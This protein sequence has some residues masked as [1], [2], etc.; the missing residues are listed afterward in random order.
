MLKILFIIFIAINLN[1]FEILKLSKD[2]INTHTVGFTYFLEET[3]DLN[4]PNK[5]L[6]N[7]K[8]KLSKN[9]YIG[10]KSGPYWTQF[11]IKNELNHNK[12]FIISSS[13][14][15]ADYVDVYIYNKDKNLEKKYS[16]GDMREQAN[17][18]ILYRNPT[19]LVNIPANETKTIVTKFYNPGMYKIN[20]NIKDTISFID[21][22]NTHPLYLDIFIAVI[23]M[24]IIATGL[25]YKFYHSKVY[26][27]ILLEAILIPLYT[28]SVYG[29]LYELDI[30]IPL[31]VISFFAWVILFFI[32]IARLIFP[33]L[34]FDLK[35]KYPKSFVLLILTS[36]IFIFQAL[37]IIY[38][39]YFDASIIEPFGL[40]ILF[41]FF[42]YTFVLLL[43]AV[44]MYVKKEPYAI[45]YLLMQ[46][47]IVVMSTIHTL[48][49]IGILSISWYTP[50]LLHVMLLVDSAFIL[51][52]QYFSSKNKY[53]KSLEQNE[54]LLDQSRFYT[55][56]QTIGHVSHQWKTPLSRLGS[57]ISVID[58]LVQTD[59]SKVGDFVEEKIDS[60]NSHIEEMKFVVDNFSNIYSTSLQKKEFLLK[61]M[62]ENNIIILFE[63]KIVIKNVEFK[64]NIDDDLKVN[65]H[66]HVLSNIFMILIDNS[67]DAFDSNSE[68]KNIIEINCKKQNDNSYEINYSDNAGGIK[69]EPIEKVFE[70]FVSTKT[71]KESSGIGLP[72]L[73]LLV[74]DK[75]N[76]TVKVSN[77]N[78]GVIF[79]IRF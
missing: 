76:G 63:S 52:L 59:K 74:T 18:E 75:L 73:K 62:I 25:L 43:V 12:D 23:I 72:L 48:S 2:K 17:Q 36:S 38:T 51:I 46:V 32:P 8:L 4:T 65:S 24:I 30:G 64:L 16:L 39:R 6:N 54:M 77:S 45:Y 69:I 15:G 35:N 67:M 57:T 33:I 60:I 49:V 27:V 42:I 14:A 61:E 66:K 7:P 78:I 9:N 79:H 10:M 47:F 3:K 50:H 1:A 58:M 26:L 5:V 19:F 71:Q 22:K 28:L 40:L 31:F 37:L 21:K 53:Q 44:F 11:T 34:F 55:I 68:D 41:S 56:G 29:Y 20:F 13:H 70:Y